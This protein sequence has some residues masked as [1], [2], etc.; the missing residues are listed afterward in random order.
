VSGVFSDAT[1]DGAGGGGSGNIAGWAPKSGIEGLEVEAVAEE[2]E[3]NPQR[4][5]AN[6][7]VEK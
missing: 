5:S 6:G 7:D 3:E 2:P 4:K 1:S